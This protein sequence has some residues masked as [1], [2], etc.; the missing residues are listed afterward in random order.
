MVNTEYK[1]LESE[2]VCSGCGELIRENEPA[3]TL[4]G[5]ETIHNFEITLCTKCGKQLQ[6]DMSADYCIFVNSKR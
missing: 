4:K 2:E 5:I 6:S 1:R 3:H